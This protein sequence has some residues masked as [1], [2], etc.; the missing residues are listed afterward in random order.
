MSQEFGQDLAGN[1][2]S[3][4]VDWVPLVVLSWWLG[5]PKSPNVFTH[6]PGTHEGTD[7][8]VSPAGSLPCFSSVWI[9]SM[10][11]EPG[12]SELAC[13][14]HMCQPLCHHSV[15]QGRHRLVHILG[16]STKGLLE[17]RRVRERTGILN[18]PQPPSH[19]SFTYSCRTYWVLTIYKVPSCMIGKGV[20]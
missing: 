18:R 12:L 4:C 19:L 11:R 5:C 13:V 6:M 3:H 14:T 17:K 20:R 15:S 16:E 10:S 8:R 1:S 9:S 7:G 2:T